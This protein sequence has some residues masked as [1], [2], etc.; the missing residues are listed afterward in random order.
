MIYSDMQ[1]LEL[2][3]C[4]FTLSHEHL[5]EVSPKSGNKARENQ[6]GVIGNKGLKTRKRQKEILGQR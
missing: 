3:S 2:I 4:S 6:H 5:V 1:G